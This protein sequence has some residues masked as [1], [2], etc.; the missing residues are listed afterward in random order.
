MEKITKSFLA[1]MLI[2]IGMVSAHAAEAP[3][4]PS[5][6]KASALVTDGS[7]KQ[8]LFNVGAKGFFVGANDY[9]TR[10]SIAPDK[11]YW[12]KMTPNG[13]TF[14]LANEAKGGNSADCQSDNGIWV[15]GAGR[16]GDGL[17]TVDVAA[18]GSFKIGKKQIVGH[19]R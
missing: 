10:A 13:E 5:A 17:W 18:D 9:G 11:G 8:Y 12:V 3:V 15:D 16:G 1:L 4:A 14:T 7:V 6:P 19:Q 2:L